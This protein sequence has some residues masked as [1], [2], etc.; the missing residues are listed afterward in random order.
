MSR[1]ICSACEKIDELKYMNNPQLYCNLTQSTYNDS[2]LDNISLIFLQI[3]LKS[4]T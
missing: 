3:N 4:F 1:K 2:K